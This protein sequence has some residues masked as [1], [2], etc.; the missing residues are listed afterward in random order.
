MNPRKGTTMKPMC[1]CKGTC[2]ALKVGVW[3]AVVSSVACKPYLHLHI[4]R[5]KKYKLLFH[6]GSFKKKG[7]K[8]DTPKPSIAG[9]CCACKI[10]SGPQR[11]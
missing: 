2:K 8:Y 6:K 4:L 1:T 9:P 11:P 5:E 7:L 10:K 3:L